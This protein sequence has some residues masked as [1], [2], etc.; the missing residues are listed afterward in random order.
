MKNHLIL[1]FC[2]FVSLFKQVF[3]ADSL[4]YAKTDP[5]IQ[6]TNENIISSPAGGQVIDFYL[7][8]QSVAIPMSPTLPI[9]GAITI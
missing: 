1:T 7:D 2:L 9:P 4:L 5:D 8:L 6:I 3:L